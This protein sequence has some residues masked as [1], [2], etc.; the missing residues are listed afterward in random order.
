MNL[1]QPVGERPG[2]VILIG[3]FFVCVG[4]FVHIKER[5]TSSGIRLSECF[6]QNQGAEYFI[7][8]QNVGTIMVFDSGAFLEVGW[9]KARGAPP[10]GHP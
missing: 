2:K 1:Q 9:R 8:R 3:P 6:S 7:P 10:A 4:R 5:A